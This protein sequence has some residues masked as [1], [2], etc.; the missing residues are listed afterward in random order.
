M[1]ILMVNTINL[2]KN[3]ITSFIVNSSIVLAKSGIDVTIG[4]SNDI[5]N[6]LRDTLKANNIDYLKLPNRKQSLLTYY[7]RLK[8][9]LINNHFDLV[10]IHGNSTTMVLELLAAKKAGIKVRIAHSHNTTTEHPYVN[11]LLRLAFNSLVTGEIACNNA[12]GEW[13]FDDNKFI[14]IKN[15]IF[16][17]NYNYDSN[18]RK[19]IR[20]KLNIKSNNIL[21]G[22]VGFFNYQKNH[23]FFLK[24]MPLLDEKY[25]LILIGD[26]IEFQ[27]FNKK[28]KAAHLENRIICIG[29]TDKVANYL[30]AMDIFALP[31][32]YEGQPF[33][34][35]EAIAT[36]LK[37]IISNNVSK[38][39]DVTKNSSFIELDA[40]KWAKSIKNYKENNRIEQ[41][42]N[43]Q[44]ILAQEG[45]DIVKNTKLLINYYLELMEKE[46]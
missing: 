13:L 31:S 46:K 33:V 14:V 8:K 42:K 18:I 35:I 10:H 16:L 3:G 26:G 24:L 36:G 5:T 9:Y 7:S 45:Y 2:E 11:K 23:D 25:K 44:E 22:H 29:L 28:V 43:N 40:E 34:I 6:E 20:N 41:Y 27:D 12:A 39:I 17:N 4:A 19:Q 15:G 32:R 30:F 37:C 21:L 38:E 1:K